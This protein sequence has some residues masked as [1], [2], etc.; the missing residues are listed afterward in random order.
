LASGSAWAS[1]PAQAGRLPHGWSDGSSLIASGRPPQA[2][3]P[4]AS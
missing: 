2:R 3:F 1:L 4:Y